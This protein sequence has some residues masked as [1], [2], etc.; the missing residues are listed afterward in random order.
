MYELQTERT[1]SATHAI[2]MQGVLEDPH[3]HDWRV[4]LTVSGQTLD[5]DGLL[6]DFH[7][8]ERLLDEA[9]APYGGVDLNSTP[10]FDT[11][12][13][14]AEHVAMHLAT[15][16]HKHLPIGL[17]TLTVAVTEAPGCVA[18]YTTELAHD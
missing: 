8:L 13:P 1:F 10:P 6:C 16:I 2:V 14:T 4:R 7:L 18:T 3:H 11:L 9:I 5:G 15:T 17:Q 12:N